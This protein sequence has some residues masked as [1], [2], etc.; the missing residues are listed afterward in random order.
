MNRFL[1][2]HFIRL[3]LAIAMALALVPAGAGALPQPPLPGASDARARLA[4]RVAPTGPGAY[5]D[6]EVIVRFKSGVATSRAGLAHVRAGAVSH[7]TL[8]VVDGLQVARLAPGGS[9]EQAIAAYEAMPDVLYA[10][11]NYIVHAIAVPG[12]PL[13]TNLWGLNNTGQT[14]NG[15]TGTAD[16]DIDAPEAWDVTTGSSDVIIAVVDTGVD[17]QHPDLDDNMWVNAAEAAGTPGV[18]DDGNG[19]ID[20]IHGYDTVNNDGDPMDDYGHG[21]HCAGTIA[22]EGN[23]GTGVTG[24]AW[25][26]S[27]MALKFLSASGSGTTADAIEAFAYADAMGAD[28]ISNSWGGWYAF[29]QAEYDAMAAMSDT[30]FVFAAGNNAKD[31]TNSWPGGTLNGIYYPAR[32]DW[33]FYPASYDLANMIVVGA[34][35]SG[36]VQASYS[37]YSA[38]RVDVH[39][40]G[41]NVLSTIPG[42]VTIASDAIENPIFSDDFSDLSAWLTVA[43]AHEPWA[44]RTDAYTSESTAAAHAGYVNNEMSFLDQAAYLDLSAGD[45]PVL[46]FQVRYDLE[47]AADYFYWGLYDPTKPEG[48]QFPILETYT[49]DTL[50]QFVEVVYDL[51]AYAGR[52]DIA[53]WFGVWSN[54][55]NSSA[56]GYDGVWLDDVEV[57]DLDAGGSGSPWAA[58]YTNAYAYYSGTSMAAPHVAGI[59]GLLLSL[60]PSLTVEQLTTAITGSV[61]VKASLAGKSTTG[62]RVNAATAVT[63]PISLADAF[64]TEMPTRTPAGVAPAS[65]GLPLTVPAPGVLGNDTDPNG[66][67]ITAEKHTDPAYGTLA[68]AADG[69]FVYTPNADFFGSDSFQYRALDSTGTYSAPTTVEIA[70]VNIPP[71]AVEDAYTVAYDT[72]LTVV[73]PGV[74]GNDDDAEEQPLTAALAT[75]SADGDVVLAADGSFTFDPAEGFSGETT[76]T[77]TAT[78]AGAAV[79]EPAT[80]TITVVPPAVINDADAGVTYTR[81][82]TEKSASFS[83]GSRV[84]T[85]GTGAWSGSAVEVEFTGSGITWIGPM[86]PSFGKADVYLDGQLVE[87]VDG[88]SP[89]VVPSAAVWA[90]GVLEDEAH[91]L[92]I[93]SV[94][95]KNP[96][97]TNYVVA[98]DGFEVTG[99][100]PAGGGS[101]ANE[102]AGTFGGTWMK[103]QLNG[104]YTG[105]TYA[106]SRWAGAKFTYAFSG[107]GVTWIGPKTTAYGRAAIY[108]DGVYRGVV[109]QYATVGG[110]GWRHRVWHAENLTAGDHVL[111]IRV[112]GTKDAASTGTIVV[113]DGIDVTP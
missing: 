106:Y 1:G 75:P 95:E 100:D 43:Y 110:T 39:A 98:V 7:R 68:L 80:V 66:D 45:H 14:V 42:V 8:P 83:G 57:F 112:L 99:L 108:L 9:V 90:S 60:D 70:V 52:N 23:S 35:G 27:I 61:D 67:A 103:N 92:R 87:R 85:Y 18:D 109:S 4:E 107:T 12:D 3:S 62:G 22:A 32:S 59:A 46:R 2:L 96:A 74:L 19:Y 77:Y 63:A 16:A 89:T 54:A 56:Q 29:S 51:G 10:E 41:S 65:I 28:V 24:V 13:F 31:I 36:D 102:P 17:Y 73:A 71:I 72:T 105:G 76:F 50:G 20:D 30:L 82:V 21:T 101:R 111:E 64:E 78:D 49:G 26:A 6:G 47:A 33:Y 91:T 38:T 25:D 86:A 84:Y 93:V 40:P 97:A 88:Y 5:V 15:V 69:S 37:N 81:W 104:T 34:T 53:L 94:A 44:L 79:S 11:P 113:V 58:D 55:A 48:S